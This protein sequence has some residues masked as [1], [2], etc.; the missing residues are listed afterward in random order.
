VRYI[1]NLHGGEGLGPSWQEVFETED[2][3]VVEKYCGE[4]DM[5]YEWKDNGGIKLI[6]VR[7]ATVFHPV[8]EEKVWFNQVDQFHPSHFNAEIYETLMLLANDNEEE[9][10][11]YASFGDGSK[12]S[13]A[14]IR[15][16]QS[17]IDN[18]TVVRPWEKGDFIIVD[19][20]LTAHGRKSYTG[21]RQIVVSMS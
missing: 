21:E 15:E 2:R 18:V 9:L 3:S 5:K 6:Q 7:P 14:I 19:N 4:I 8:T 12:I 17:T 1:R 13:E 10:P 16:V 11:L 20:M